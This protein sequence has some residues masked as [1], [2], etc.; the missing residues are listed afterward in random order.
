MA[1]DRGQHCLHMSHKKNV[2]FIWVNVTC[3]ILEIRPGLLLLEILVDF[4]F[5]FV[6][7]FIVIKQSFNLVLYFDFIFIT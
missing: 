2:R 1:S 4:D 3:N 6:F 7:V 5:I